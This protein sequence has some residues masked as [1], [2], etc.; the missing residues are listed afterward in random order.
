MNFNITLNS[1]ETAIGEETRSDVTKIFI[2]IGI[3][4]V[5]SVLHFV[6]QYIIQRKRFNNNQYYLVKVLSIVD[7][8]AVTATCLLA[9]Y[10]LIEYTL[11]RDVLVLFSLFIYVVYTFSLIVTLIIALDRWVAVK[12]CLRY[13]AIFARLRVNMI[14]FISG[15]MNTVILSCLFYNW[16]VHVSGGIE[17]LYTN[18]GAVAYMT[19]IRSITCIV[20]IA[21]GK[22]TIYLRNQSEIEMRKRTNLH[23][24]EAEKLDRTKQL[25]RSIKDV[26][27]LNLWTCIFLI[28]KIVVYPKVGYT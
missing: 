6:I 16:C 19:I 22:L 24:K 12:W 8:C 4:V 1:T 7:L 23:G 26:F 17:N 18:T 3:F 25:K 2:F 14:L 21:L 28:P 10:S 15:T 27:K 13:Y 5:T 11:S 20:I 9:V